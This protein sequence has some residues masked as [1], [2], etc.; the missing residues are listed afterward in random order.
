[1]IDTLCECSLHIV[2]KVDWLSSL[3]S[4][5]NA[6]SGIQ[7]VSATSSLFAGLSV[8]ATNAVETASM[9]SQISVNNENTNVGSTFNTRS[10]AGGTLQ[11]QL[12][13]SKIASGPYYSSSH[14]VYSQG[15]LQPQPA[16]Q[17]QSMTQPSLSQPKH[18]GVLQPQPASSHIHTQPTS[19]KQIG[20]LQPQSVPHNQPMSGSPLLSDSSRYRAPNIIQYKPPDV[21]P[22]GSTIDV[23][24]GHL[25]SQSKPLNM[26]QPQPATSF[27]HNQPVS[28]P[29]MSL[30]GISGPSS[31]MA[32]GMLQPQ[33][34][35]PILTPSTGYTP[36]I[37]G[38][39]MPSTTGAASRQ[40]V[41][42]PSFRQDIL[43]PTQSNQAQLM[44]PSSLGA[45]QMNYITTRDIQPMP[46]NVAQPSIPSGGSMGGTHS[47]A[48]LLVPERPST[49]S[50][51][52]P[53]YTPGA[54]MTIGGS[55]PTVPAQKPALIGGS[56]V[57]AP[58]QLS[59]GANPFADINDLLG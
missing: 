32:A 20:I 14:N 11:P 6:A 41:A 4:D 15:V 40:Q 51:S 33:P 42:P 50:T 47:N 24:A 39:S 55:G 43:Q 2:L 25:S 26:L 56:Q 30:S 18:M 58:Q 13:H 12:T 36:P 48:G 8:Q 52:L 16:S 10:S 35:Q 54:N 45:P 19:A 49:V 34:M 1:M 29:P 53:S 37:I 27:P 7:Q 31:F 9:S 57:S 38:I 28:K 21:T 23:S 3:K 17:N 46:V 5:D 44:Q 22:S 59:P